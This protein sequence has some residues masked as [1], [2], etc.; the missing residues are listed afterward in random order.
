[1]DGRKEGK[2]RDG[3]TWTSW[4]G[5]CPAGGSLLSP[6]PPSPFPP[7]P[8]LLSLWE[9]GEEERTRGGV[10]EGMKEEREQGVTRKRRAQ[11][12]GEGGKEG[13]KE[14]STGGRVMGRWRKREEGRRKDERERGRRQ[15]SGKDP[16]PVLVLVLVLVRRQTPAGPLPP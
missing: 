9:R 3:G 8:L 4:R 7:F 11:P 1:M 15:G 14:K 10:K 13:K 2:G 5:P 12:R 16:P 6:L